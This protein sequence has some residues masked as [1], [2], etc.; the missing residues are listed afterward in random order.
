MYA[1]LLISLLAAFVAMLG[2]QW[3]NRYLRNSGGSVIERC[4]DRQRKCDGIE[5]WPLHPFIESLPVMLQISLFLLAWG[6]CQHM[7]TIN[8][9]VAYTLVALTGVGALLYVVIVI[10]GLSSYACPFQTPV[11]TALRLPLKKLLRTI[12]SVFTQCG[13][14]LSWTRR[15]WNRSLRPSI[16]RQPPQPIPLEDVQ[17]QRPEPWLKPE[18]LTKIRKENADDARCVS[19]VLRNITDR[20][21]LD[22][23]IRLA[24]TVQW[25][26]D[27]TDVGSLYHVIVSSFHGCFDSD[28]RVHPGST[29]RA[30]YSGR[31]VVW[32][33]TL[34]R[35]YSR[36]FASR[37]L[38]QFND[39]TA[40]VSDRD[41]DLAHL[42]SITE[43]FF[44]ESS[45]S[46]A[47]S[48]IYSYFGNN[49]DHLLSIGPGHT[50]SHSQWISNLLLHDTWD[51]RATLGVGRRY[52]SGGGVS[53][54]AL[55]NRLLVWCIYLGSPI[56]EDV[57]RVPDKSYDIPRFHPSSC[58]HR[59][60]TAIY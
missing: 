2:K 17:V 9:T 10:S 22:A 45:S 14:A 44:Y 12:A 39:Y 38:F 37:Y 36:G 47:H 28:G 57:L 15:V 59:I 4:G 51:N 32:I 30:Y 8:T 48:R 40:P 26:K 35:C 19:W 53:L 13:H 43:R 7:W 46:D 34:A 23:A 3:L 6:L 24:G 21:A 54:N 1:S 5:K 49:F 25:F 18:N 29:D 42:L 55:L 31:A 16:R 20:E 41:C 27:G 33:R 52:V 58:S 60:P 50:P 56:D 11:S